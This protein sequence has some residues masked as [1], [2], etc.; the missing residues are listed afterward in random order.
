[1]LQGCSTGCGPLGALRRRATGNAVRRVREILSCIAVCL[2]IAM[3]SVQQARAELRALL[4]GI[5]HYAGVRHLNGATADARDLEAAVRRSGGKDVTLLVDAQAE[6]GAVL[7]AIAALGKRAKAGDQV[8]LGFASLGAQIKSDGA[9]VANRSAKAL[10][11]AGFDLGQPRAAHML[12]LDELDTAIAQL[13]AANVSVLAVIDAGFGHDNVRIADSRVG[14]TFKLRSLPP[15]TLADAAQ[16]KSPPAA[17]GMRTFGR[18]IILE[19]G[20]GRHAVPEI[21]IFGLEGWRGA[22]SFAIARGIEMT[23]ENK[24]AP[25]LDDLAAYARHVA[26]QLSD[27]RQEVSV[28]GAT[29][30]VKQ[31]AGPG[32]P[33]RVQ[34]PQLPPSS[35]VKSKR[36]G[37]VVPIAALDGRI[38]HFQGI[39]PDETDFVV[40]APNQTPSLVWDPAK[41][42]VITG[43]DVIASEVVRDDIPGIVDRLIAVRDIKRLTAQSP[44]PMMVSPNGGIHR[45]GQRVT[46]EIEGLAKRAL[47]LFSIAGNGKVQLLY[48]IGSDPPIISTQTYKLELQVQEPFGADQLVAITA[49]ERMTDIE[50]ALNRLRDRRASGQLPN[51]LSHYAPPNWRIGSVG[52]FTAR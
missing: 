23:S 38:E 32:M 44:Q 27:E 28:L 24:A 16:T 51:I 33:S 14:Q 39:A 49:P 45:S 17:A 36:R 6:R 10:L 11:L 8:V 9:A 31:V 48:P 2:V 3:T 19:A 26:Y 5:D 15:L 46:V 7:N 20:S 29:R 40:V 30:S 41:R 37:P 18:S 43:G 52:I 50:L 21:E 42:E 12:R 35:T 1:M 47:V 34:P 25:Q 13:E 4:I 22:L